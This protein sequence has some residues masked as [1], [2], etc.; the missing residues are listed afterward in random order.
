V[1][2]SV[3]YKPSGYFVNT[4]NLHANKVSPTLEIYYRTYT[5]SAKSNNNSKALLSLISVSSGMMGFGTSETSRYNG[6]YIGWDNYPANGKYF[7][8]RPG[9]AQRNILIK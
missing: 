3:T 2:E 6:P 1:Y 8:Y 9:G 5:Y 7:D 4:K